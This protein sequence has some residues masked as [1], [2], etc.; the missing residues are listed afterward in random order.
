[1]LRESVAQK[2]T[3]AVSWGT[4][5]FQN[6]PLVLNLL[7]CPKSTDTSPT[8]TMAHATS[9]NPATIKNGAAQLSSH[10]I[11]LMPCQTKCRFTSQ[12]ARKQA[13]CHQV[14]PRDV[15]CCAWSAAV[16]TQPSPPST[17]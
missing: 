2:P 4:K 12:K 6:S 16:S 13:S 17:W 9:A 7:P 8:S 3:M 5:T 15:R 10:L 1:M 11:E 14:T